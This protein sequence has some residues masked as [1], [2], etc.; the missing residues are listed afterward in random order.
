MDELLPITDYLCREILVL[1]RDKS[2]DVPIFNMKYMQLDYFW[3][4]LRKAAGF[5]S[6][7]DGYKLRFKDLR[8]QTSQYGAMAGIPQQ[9]LASTYG[10]SGE[11][12]IRRYQK[13]NDAMSM[14]QAVALENQMFGKTGTE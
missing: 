2:P 8:A 4:R 12:M 3:N 11:K 14:E 1:V 10:H 6:E 13:Y 7:E 5:W 9:V